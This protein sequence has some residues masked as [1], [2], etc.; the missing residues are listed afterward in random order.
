MGRYLS[1]KVNNETQFIFYLFFRFLRHQKC[2][3]NWIEE[4]QK[5][6]KVLE[7]TREKE[8]IEN[9]K[10]IKKPIQEIESSVQRMYNEAERRQLK[11]EKKKNQVIEDTN[12]EDFISK[13][14]VENHTRE[15]TPTIF[16]PRKQNKQQKYQFNYIF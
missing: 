14:N 4:K 1:R 3:E 2:K 7:E 6:K 13:A 9:C 10:T 16:R 8:I 15:L 5:E 11:F 12:V